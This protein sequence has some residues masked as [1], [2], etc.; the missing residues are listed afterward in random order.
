MNFDK[1]FKIAKEKGVESIQCFYE[2][3][4]QLDLEVF[5]GELEKHQ[6]AD[7]SVLTISGI[8]N[9]KMGKM[10]TEV[11]DLEEAEFWVDEI[12][13]S[14]SLI[15]SM[16]EVFIFEGSKSYKAL[17]GLYQAELNELPVEKKIQ[18]VFDLEEKLRLLDTRVDISEA[19]YSEVTKRVL[20]QNSKGLKLEKEVNNAIFGA[21]V[22]ARED[23]DSRSAF[24]YVQSNILADFNVDQIAND[25]VKKATSL[26]GA[27]AIKSGDYEIVLQNTASAS[28]LQAYLSMFSAE[29]VQKGMSK[30]K[31]K[32]GENIANEHITIVDDP[33]MT[34]SPR[35]G[36]FDDEGVSSD[37]KEMVSNGK[38]TTY[39][40]NLK[41]AKKADTKSTGNGF[42][43]GVSPTNFYIKSGSVN[44]DE[45]VASMKKGLI[46]TDL[47]GTHSGTNAISGDFSLQASGFLVEEGK[48]VKPVALI[49]VAGN[50]LD[51]LS[52]VTE[53]CDDLKFSFSFIGSP[54]LK[55]KSLVVSGE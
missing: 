21:H 19:F 7:T 26:L 11:I 6:M 51:M 35:S 17:E 15:E 24:E 12:I 27:K 32:I 36:A 25:A 45:A 33:H 34:K 53:V 43:G 30:L 3:S 44:Y 40:H 18:L 20:L 10:V 4:S 55:I 29:S 42:R 1:V 31:D 39:L 41:T 46:I 23:G 13:K 50:Y 37:Y 9:G 52:E 5:K 54:S 22:V 28:L 2:S 8:Y 38:L 16:D 48:V 49:T 47:A 14:A